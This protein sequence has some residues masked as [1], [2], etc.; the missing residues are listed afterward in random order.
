MK[1]AIYF[2]KQICYNTQALEYMHYSKLSACCKYVP[3]AQL[4]RVLDSDSKGR[5]FESCRAYQNRGFSKGNPRFCNKKH[6]LPMRQK[7]DI[8]EEKP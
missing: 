1:T 8:Q 7:I 2:S 4:D 3:V 5:R 6:S